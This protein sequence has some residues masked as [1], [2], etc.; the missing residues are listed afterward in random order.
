MGRHCLCAGGCDWVYPTR[1]F[2]HSALFRL[3]FIFAITI[4]AV[5]G[6]RDLAE[7]MRESAS[8]IWKRFLAVSILVA[9]CALLVS[10]YYFT[11]PAIAG[12]SR[13]KD[14]LAY[15]HV[16]M[17]WLG[18]CVVAVAGWMSPPRFRQLLVPVLLLALA[19]ADAGM[20]TF[21]SIETIA[22]RD[23]NAVKRWKV[24]DEKHS[25]SLDLTPRGLSREDASIY[26][27][28]SYRL[29]RTNDQMITK[30]PVFNSYATAQNTYQE[31]MF[32]HPKMKQID[33]KSVV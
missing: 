10:L 20:T 28:G 4:L 12:V 21:L 11:S 29:D 5:I 18:I 23:P 13:A 30:I 15:I 25:A 22:D 2:R 17:V 3:Y 24:L 33:R 1:F 9:A 6:T 19:A 31:A 27:D 26:Q 16:F 7:A 14:A 32:A 8:R